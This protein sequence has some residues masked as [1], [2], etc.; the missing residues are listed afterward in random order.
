[1]FLNKDHMTYIV[2]FRCFWFNSWFWYNFPL[3]YKW[4]CYVKAKG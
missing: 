3:L 4:L 2:N 1:M